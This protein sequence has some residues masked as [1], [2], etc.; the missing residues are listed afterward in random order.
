MIPVGLDAS[1][2]LKCMRVNYYT[3]EFVFG[4]GRGGLQYITF[5]MD[6]TQWANYVKEHGGTL[7]YK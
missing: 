1:A 6:D 2:A 3:E 5:A 7:D 4:L